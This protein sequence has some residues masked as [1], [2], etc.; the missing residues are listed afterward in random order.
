MKLLI[1]SLFFSLVI[2][3]TRPPKQM[4]DRELA[5]FVGPVKMVSGEFELIQGTYGD[6]L[7]GK[8]CRDFR[9][10]YDESGRLTQR[11]VYPG[12]CG[13]DEDIELYKYEA[14]GSR[15]S[16][17]LEIHNKNSPPPPPPIAGPTGDSD[18]T[19]TVREI[20]R[21]DS[22]GK[23]V[24]TS[25]VRGKGKLLFKISYE[26]DSAGRLTETRSQG[27]GNTTPVRRVWGYDGDNKVPMAFS[28]INGRGQIE[29]L[30]S[31]SEYE[32]NPQG[33]WIKRKVR[34]TESLNR[35]QTS[36]ETRKIEYFK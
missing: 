2:V 28:Y 29:E 35:R 9:E 16:T 7:I 32:F 18:D 8:Q 27:A 34:T 13:A 20:F 11:S 25:S 24:E 6:Q 23:L 36:I 15:A 19:G 17:H 10:I 33:D 22:A 31:Y 21:Y 5:G 4:S 1:L 12:S 26:Y 30:T 14:D 3:Q